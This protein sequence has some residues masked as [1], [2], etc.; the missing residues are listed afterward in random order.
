MSFANLKK[1]STSFMD[2]LRNEANKVSGKNF[3]DDADDRFWKPTRDKS[4]NGQAIIR[5]LPSAPDGEDSVPYVR[6]YSH[7]TQGPGGWYIE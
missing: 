3:K 1:T 6:V 7:G 5:F 4:G 2:N